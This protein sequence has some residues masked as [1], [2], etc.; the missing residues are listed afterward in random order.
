MRMAPGVEVVV[1]PKVMFKVPRPRSKVCTVPALELSF[2]VP[3]VADAVV[4]VWP[5]VRM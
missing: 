1:P 5:A 2:R 4:W 3:M